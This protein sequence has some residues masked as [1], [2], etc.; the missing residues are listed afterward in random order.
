MIEF[1]KQWLY[2]RKVRENRSKDLVLLDEL[3]ERLYNKKYGKRLWRDRYKKRLDDLRNN[4]EEHLKRYNEEY[5]DK[6]IES[7]EKT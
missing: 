5:V 4:K 3:Q 1:I 6:A 2:K 7:A